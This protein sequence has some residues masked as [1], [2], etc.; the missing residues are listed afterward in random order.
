MT[1]AN[2]PNVVSIE[3]RL[4]KRIRRARQEAGMTLVQLAQKLN[5]SSGMAV[6]RYENGTRQV[7]LGTLEL[8]ARSTGKSIIWFMV[9]DQEGVDAQNGWAKLEFLFQELL[10]ATQENLLNYAEYLHYRQLHEHAKNNK[11][12]DCPSTKHTSIHKEAV[13][14]SKAAIVAEEGNEFL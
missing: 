8:I 7:S 3:K 12:A 13:D 9:D 11:H 1:T 14:H 5:L 4:G 6:S 2:P 10:P